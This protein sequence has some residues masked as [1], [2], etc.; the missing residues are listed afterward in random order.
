[1]NEL[2]YFCDMGNPTINELYEYVLHSL[3]GSSYLKSEEGY[4]HIIC[5]GLTFDI[6]IAQ[7]A[8]PNIEETNQKR[9]ISISQE[10]LVQQFVKIRNR[11]KVLSGKAQKI[12]ARETVLARIDKKQ[13]LEFQEEHHLQIALPGKYRYGLYYKGELVSIAIFSG[14]RKMHEK[15]LD[16]RSFELLRFCQKS[17]HLVIGGLSKLLKAFIKDFNANDIMTYVDLDWSQDSSLK[18]LGF[19]EKGIKKGENLWI[20]GNRQFIITD[21]KMLMET[22]ENHPNGFLHKNTGSIKLVLAV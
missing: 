2:P 9:K 18:K 3:D 22:I 17:D 15:P 13:T 11:L 6:Y 10:Q 19:E 8:Y 21:D 4:S 16:Y 20:S 5:P 14:G 12:Y 7:A 1:M